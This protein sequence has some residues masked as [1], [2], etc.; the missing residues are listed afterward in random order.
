MKQSSVIKLIILVCVI[1]IAIVIGMISIKDKEGIEITSRTTNVGLVITGQK[2]DANFCQTHYDAL[3]EIKDE[4]N[5]NIIC[6]ENI[7]EDESCTDAIREL[8]EREKCR[9]IVA[10][11]YGYGEY[12]TEMAETYPRVCFIQP[13]GTEKRS[14]MTSCF[15]RM[16]QARYLSG[17]VAG[18]RTQTGDIGYVAAF[19]ISEVIRGINAF[20]RGVKSVSPDANVHV[21]YCNSWIDD[22]AAGKA[23]RQLL[24]KCADIDVMAMHTNSMEP[25]RVAMEKGIW[26]VGFNKDNPELFPGSYL[27]ACVWKW[28]E[29]YRDQILSFLKGKFIGTIDWISME[30]GIVGLSD[31]TE[32]CA[33]GTK[34]AV[35]E[36][37][38]AF[39]ERSFDVFY[40]PVVD[41]TG[42][43]RIPEGES[44]SD[45]EMLNSFDWYVEGVIVEE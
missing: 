28:D 9:V 21:I 16:Y 35:D 25:N 41:N 22:E 19:P 6:R 30:D 20:T 36:A 8:V 27:T 2:N 12:V 10:A 31:L 23:G 11:S 43:I 34:E 39:E 4:L 15:G 26:S 13:S 45:S 38:R 44:M 32:E 40:G 1:F 18:M 7:P 29:Y 5:L 3:M 33:P 14:N 17:I 42:K 37:V 24:D